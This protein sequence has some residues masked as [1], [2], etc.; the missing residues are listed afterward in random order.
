LGTDSPNRRRGALPA[1]VDG[2]IAP[3]PVTPALFATYTADEYGDPADA[4]R[5]W[6][7]LPDFDQPENSTLAE[8]SVSPITV[9]PFDPTS[10]FGR[11]DIAQPP[12][13]EFLD[14]QSDRIAHRL[15]YRNF[16]THESLVVNQTIRSSQT[17]ATY[18]AGL[19]LYEL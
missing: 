4:T 13:G 17:G 7:F 19:R 10:P 2:L 16:G 6:E 5:L 11:A 15:A 14:S 12:P 9:S 1:D 3:T 18:R 8:A